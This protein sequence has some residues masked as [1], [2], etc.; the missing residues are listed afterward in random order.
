MSPVL[1]LAVQMATSHPAHTFMGVILESMHGQ[2]STA[3]E[4]GE[5]R[6]REGER[7]RERLRE[8][9]RERGSKQS[10]EEQ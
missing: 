9:E 5:T 10:E 6:Q 8:T 4:Q 2:P 3:D 7:E 1:S